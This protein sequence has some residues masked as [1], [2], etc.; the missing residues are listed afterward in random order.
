M[1]AREQSTRFAPEKEAGPNLEPRRGI[2]D[3]RP[4]AVIAQ[5]S[6]SP[7]LSRTVSRAWYAFG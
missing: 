3:G 5:G 2:R 6:L 7:M 1:A 4:A